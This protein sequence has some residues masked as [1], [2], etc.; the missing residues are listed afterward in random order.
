MKYIGQN[1][2]DLVSKFRQKVFLEAS[3]LEIRKISGQPTLELSAWSATATA[4]H[5]GRIKFLKSGTAAFDTLTAGNH[6]TAGEILGRIEAYGVDDGDGETLAAYIEFANDAVSDA[7]SSPGKIIFATSDADDAGTPTARLTIDDDGLATFSGAVSIGGNLTFDS[8]ALTGIQIN[9]ESF[10]NDDVSLMTSA[11]I[12]TYIASFGYGT[13]DITGMRLTADD[14]NVITDNTGSIDFTVAGGEGIDTSVSSTTLTIAG[15][16]ATT[17]N[18]GVAS[19]SSNNFSVSSG[20]VSL[21]T[22][23]TLDTLNFSSTNTT[24]PIISLINY[25]DDQ[26][27]STLRFAK[28]RGGVD[29]ASDAQDNDVV[30]NILFASVD[31]GTPSAQDYG[32]IESVVADATSGQEAGN[33]NFYVPSYDGVL[34]KGLTLLGDTNA[35]GEV[36]VTIAAGAASTTTISGNLTV[37]G[38]ITSVGDDVSIGDDLLFTSAAGKIKFEGTAGGG[39]EGVLYKDAGGTNRNALFFPGSDV[40]AVANRASNGTVEIR[41]NTST[42]GSSG[43]V[44]QVTVED[45]KVTIAGSLELGHA[46]DTTLA[47]SASGV[48]TIEGNKIVTSGSSGTNLIMLSAGN[49][50]LSTITADEWY[51]GNNAYGHTYHLWNNVKGAITADEGTFTMSEDHNLVG[52]LVPEALSKVK[53]QVSARPSGSGATGEVLSA[54]ICSADRDG[55]GTNTTWTVL[56]Q[57]T[58]TQVQGEY[59]GVDITYTGSIATSKMLAVGVGSTESGSIGTTNV[60]FTYALTGYIT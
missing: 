3:D 8:V 49:G 56:A 27:G 43:E 32:K 6:T 5:A 12:A 38:D 42:A 14:S 34:T 28:F 47:R 48:V 33:L 41:A 23:Q 53:L 2:Y 19:F 18:K 39:G 51:F 7:D 52:R 10:S 26:H 30:G 25:T 22:T 36:D 40:V 15:E 13:G 45:D 35:D 20:A 17:S 1:I 55:A 31:D 60:R 59:D 4:A 11:A 54:C 21:N 9:S 24:D 37:T 58:I 16:D 57:G 50:Y 44:T 46:S 29:P